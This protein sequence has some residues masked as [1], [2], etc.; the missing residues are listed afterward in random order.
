MVLASVGAYAAFLAGSL[1]FL[2]WSGGWWALAE[3]FDA[4]R[5]GRGEPVSTVRWAYGRVGWVG[6]NGIFIMG[7][8]SDGLYVAVPRP[9]SFTTPPLHVPWSALRWAG[10]RGWGPFASVS[11]QVEGG[12]AIGIAARAWSRLDP[13]LRARIP[14]APPVGASSSSV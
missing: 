12:A 9:F 7:V 2:G 11:L 5:Q 10:E 13:A 6:Y 14:G 3:R 1:A 4:A 8:D